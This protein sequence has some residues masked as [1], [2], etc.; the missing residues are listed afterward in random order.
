MDKKYKVLI[1]LKQLGEKWSYIYQA[2]DICILEKMKTRDGIRCALRRALYRNGFVSRDVTV[3]VSGKDNFDYIKNR[4]SSFKNEIE[5][6]NSFKFRV[7][8]KRTIAALSLFKHVSNKGKVFRIDYPM[9]LSPKPDKLEN[10][11]A[12]KQ[13]LDWAYKRD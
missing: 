1:F 6:S 3:Y 8:R 10:I 2:G 12:A 7:I 9:N 4:S 5:R 11:L 13:K